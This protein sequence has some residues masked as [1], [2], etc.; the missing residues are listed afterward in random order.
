M[1]PHSWKPRALAA[2][3]LESD[4]QSDEAKVRWV[5]REVLGR[6][7][8]TAE[9]DVLMEL[10][11]KHRAHFAENESAASELVAVGISPVRSELDAAELA[12][13]T[14]VSRALLN[15]DETITRN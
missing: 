9:A 13:W 3:V 1:I 12:A 15:L 7:A 8:E 5:W 10:L 11:A 14:S 2:R 4:A 6:E